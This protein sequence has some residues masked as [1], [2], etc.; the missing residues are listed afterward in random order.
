MKVVILAGGKGTRM[1]SLSQ[2]IPKPMINI[3]NKPILQYQIE[4][5]KR[6]NLT[7]IILLTGYKGEVVEDYFGNGE[8]WGV[9]ISCYRETIPLGTAGAVKEVEDYLHDDFLVFYGDVIMD[10]D[11]K[12]VIRYHM[13]RKPIATLVVHPNDHPYDSDLIEVN[14]E[15]K[16]ITFHSK[17]HKQDIF[18]RNLVNAALYILSP[19]IMN[20]CQKERILISEKI[21]F[22]NWLMTAK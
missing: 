20:F 10:I 12:S 3:A 14:N 15:G 1:G 16:V 17:P 18:I 9:N 19:R 2:N 21:F 4:I 11:L 5:A 7:D 22:Q 13:K 8:N 6:F